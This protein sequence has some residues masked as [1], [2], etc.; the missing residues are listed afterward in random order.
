MLAE[1]ERLDAKQEK[2]LEACQQ[3]NIDIVRLQ[4]K[5]GMWGALAGSVPAI[6][7]VILMIMKS[8]E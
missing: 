5:A 1:L 8:W 2:I 6:I 3:T 4:M 7:A